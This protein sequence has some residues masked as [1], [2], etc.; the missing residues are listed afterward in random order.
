MTSYTK[1]GEAGGVHRA[2]D[3]LLRGMKKA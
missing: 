2:V 3:D 1:T